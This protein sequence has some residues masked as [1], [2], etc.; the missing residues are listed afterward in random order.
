L[1]LKNEKPLILT[2]ESGY[3]G[4]LIDDLVTRGTEEPYRMMTSRTE[5]RLLHRQDNA[6]LRLSGYG[7]R[8]GL[9]SQAR[10]G[11]V[12]EKYALVEREIRRLEA[13]FIP[14]SDALAEILVPLGEPPPPSG[15]SL[16]SLLRR[17][18]VGYEALA[19]LDPERPELPASVREAAEI[20]VKYEGYIKRQERQ[21][22]EARRMESREIPDGVDYFSINGL[23]LEARQKLDRIRPRSLGQASRI[24]GVS[25]ADI[26]VL[27]I[28]LR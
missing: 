8:A 11:R 15:V 13:M 27:M 12:L 18:R 9:I 10:H 14:P 7:L 1:K 4:V 20:A 5:Y 6:D 19:V 24:S 17:P 2:R 3:I 23:R 22:E 25:P 28:F 21:L 26:A 16:A